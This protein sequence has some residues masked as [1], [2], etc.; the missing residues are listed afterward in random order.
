MF[1]TL[2]HPEDFLLAQKCLEG[3]PQAIQQLQEICRT[4]V[5]NYLVHAGASGEEARELAD[6][7][8]ADCLAERK[9]NRPR[10]ATYGGNSP[11]KTWL[12]VVA[13]NKLIQRKRKKSL[14]P[15]P[16]PGPEPGPGTAEPPA[17]PVYTAEAPLLEIMRD[18]VQLA[19]RECDAE[20]FVLVQ[21][22]HANGLLGRELALMFSCSEATVSRNLERTRKKIVAVTLECIRK[23]DPWLEIQWED[24]V[25]LCRVASP[26]CFGIE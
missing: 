16:P 3:D 18:A 26:A 1:D 5:V 10:L 21:L 19:F 11:L 15:P 23:Q 14:P 8:P 13:L 17:P 22:A 9:E 6:E 25:E 4:D 20:D 2:P 12:K 24:F 7:L